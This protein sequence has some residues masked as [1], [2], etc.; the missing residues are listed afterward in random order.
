[1]QEGNA[2]FILRLPLKLLA[3]PLVMAPS[4]LQ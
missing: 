2:M 1:M 3:L 4:L